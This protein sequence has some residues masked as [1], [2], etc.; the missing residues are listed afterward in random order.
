MSFF[1]HFCKKNVKMKIFYRKKLFLLVFMLNGMTLFFEFV[2]GYI[3]DV[4]M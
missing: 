4:N 1:Y 3:I 2:F